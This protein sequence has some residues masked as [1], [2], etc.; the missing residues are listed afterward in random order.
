MEFPLFHIPEAWKGTPF[1]RS[2]PVKC[3][4]EGRLVYKSSS[5]FFS[6]AKREQE[7]LNVL[8]GKA[9]GVTTGNEKQRTLRK[10]I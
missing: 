6:S 10:S 5:K 9:L 7:I 2:R 1:G 8:G 3:I 4:I